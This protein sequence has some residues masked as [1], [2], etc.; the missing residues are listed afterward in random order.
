MNLSVY[1]AWSYSCCPNVAQIQFNLWQ[2]QN[3]MPKSVSSIGAL[4]SQKGQRTACS[5]WTIMHWKPCL[6]P[7]VQSF[8]SGDSQLLTQC[9]QHQLM[10]LVCGRNLGP[11]HGLLSNAELLSF[12]NQLA[13]GG[14]I[15]LM[16]FANTAQQRNSLV[17]CSVLLETFL[18]PT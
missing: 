15:V 6:W 1:M 3:Q 11:P 4:G 8:A 9:Q 12:R 13:P 2:G 14:G 7:K 17:S 10:S 16:A 18:F 5:F